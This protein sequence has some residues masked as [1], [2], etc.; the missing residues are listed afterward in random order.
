MKVT[1]IIAEYDPFHNGHEYH[2]KE[3]K[4]R[5]GADASVA[6]I[7]GSF[8]QR[9]LPCFYGKAARARAALA[10]GVDLILELP[11]FYSCGAAEEFAGGSVRILERLGVVTDLVFGSE[12]ED[13][14]LLRKV[15]DFLSEDRQGD[16]R[17]TSE[18]RRL[19]SEGLSYPSA[20]C[21]AV[22][23]VLGADCGD[24]LRNPNNVLGIEYLKALRR[25]KSEIQP[26]CIL[27]KGSEHRE[28]SLAETSRAGETGCKSVGAG[29]DGLRLASASALRNAVRRGGAEQVAAYLPAASE[30]IFRQEP[31]FCG[32][33]EMYR[34]LRYRLITSDEERLREIYG[35]DEG[36]EHRLKKAA[37]LS[38]TWEDFLA[39]VR[40]KRYTEARIRRM[41]AH[42]LNDYSK[43][44]SEIL[45]TA[46][47]AR[48]LGFSR[49]GA[50]LLREIRER[51]RIEVVS[52]LSKLSCCSAQTQRALRCEMRASDLRNLL[53]GRS[54]SVFSDRRI[55]PARVEEPVR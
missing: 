24:I 53:M 22:S 6:V 10:N 36:I 44:D 35:V 38:E 23:G 37:L 49:K 3:A 19:I 4:R 27:R 54:L 2:L 46:S 34:L 32:E 39:G 17:F 43:A 25:L 12:C 13:L 5:T 29:G 8:T 55:V 51:G 9:G 14:S 47:Y 7:S 21:L 41:S 48:V 52:N 16:S 45:K 50:Q 15:A 30:E 18:L 40:T 1:G 33:E 20:V 28:Q 11:Y 31:H 26:H 42:I